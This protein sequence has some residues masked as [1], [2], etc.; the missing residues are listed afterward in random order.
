MVKQK[1]KD[2]DEM[3][4]IE[5]TMMLVGL[6]V[7]GFIAIIVVLGIVA[8]ATG[9]SDEP[10]ENVKTEQKNNDKPKEQTKKVDNTEEKEVTKDK[11]TDP[12]MSALRRCTVME[13][14]D[15]HTTG[16]GA[17]SDNVFNDGRKYCESSLKTVYKNDKNLF[18]KDVDIDWAS[19]KDKDVDGKP[20][21]YYLE[22]LGW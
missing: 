2:W 7:I 10:K 20:L 15:I 14:Y 6:V 18:I 11:A 19:N 8:G 5:K 22:I 3:S 1:N 4:K 13:G 9:S 21:T 17:Q 12:F 16:A